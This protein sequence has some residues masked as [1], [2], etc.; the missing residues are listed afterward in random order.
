MRCTPP[1]HRMQK[2]GWLQA[3]W[4]LRQQ[5]KAKYYWPTAAGERELRKNAENWRA[6]RGRITR[7][8]GHGMIRVEILGLATRDRDSRPPAFPAR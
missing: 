3:E 4:G 8:G 5:R 6:T 1:S 7:T 2:R